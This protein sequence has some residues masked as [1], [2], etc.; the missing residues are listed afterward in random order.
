MTAKAKEKWYNDS[1]VRHCYPRTI[2]KKYTVIQ[3]TKPLHNL[4]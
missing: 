4:S 3:K 1:I 2:F